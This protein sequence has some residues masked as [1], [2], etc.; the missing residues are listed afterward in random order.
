MAERRRG[1]RGML[2][3]LILFGMLGTAAV[4]T[5]IP[6]LAPRL[7]TPLLHAHDTAVL[8]LGGDSIRIHALDL[9]QDQVKV[10][11]AGVVGNVP[12]VHERLILRA[13]AAFCAESLRE[14]AVFEQNFS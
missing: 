4:C 12:A 3:V 1:L 7:W 10:M 9:A 2:S 14:C 13:V 5:L 6:E 11:G 8:A